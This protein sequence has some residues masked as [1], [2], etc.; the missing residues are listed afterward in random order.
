MRIPDLVGLNIV[1]MFIGGARQMF[2]GFSSLVA[3]S[4]NL[5]SVPSSSR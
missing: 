3:L 2:H 5:D 4:E 1:T